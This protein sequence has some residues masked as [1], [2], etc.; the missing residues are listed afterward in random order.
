[1]NASLAHALAPAASTTKLLMGLIGSG[2]QKSLTPAMQEEEARRHGVRLHYQLIDLDTTGSTVDALPN[3]IDAAR[4]MNY[5]G[6]NITF[7]CKQAVLPLLDGLSDEAAAIGAVNTVVHRDGRL[8][9][10][11]TDCSGWAW[12]FQRALPDA[13]LSRVVLLGTGGA[14]AAIAHAV[15]RMAVGRLVL[16]DQDPRRAIELAAQLNARYGGER[17]LAEADVVRAMAGASGLIHATPTG[18]DK[19]PGLPL[20]ADLLQPA[21]WV[22]EVVYFPLETALL[23]AARA[24]G[25]RTVDGGGMAVG[26]AIGAFELVTGLKAD[27]ERMLAHFLS[28]IGHR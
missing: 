11:N 26:Q 21:M 7:P 20:P 2:I 10:H 9:G 18:M 17:A 3:L 5:A 23:K 13:D 24:K 28:L 22:S 15:M 14:G 4:T 19:L 27:P 12:G 25:C 6:L 8:V 16:V 1:M